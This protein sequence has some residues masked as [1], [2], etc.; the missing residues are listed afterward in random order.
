MSPRREV[1]AK[2]EFYH[3]CS[4]SIAGYVIFNHDLEFSRMLSLIRYYQLGEVKVRFSD[5][6]GDAEESFEEKFQTYSRGKEKRVRM[7]AY[8][9]MP[10]HIH[11]LLQQLE[12]GG[13][14]RY[15][16]NVLNG[17][18]RY[19]NLKHKRR[20]PLWE[21]RFKSILVKIDSQL[22]H[23]T[24]YIHLNPTT[25]HLANSPEEWQYSS[26]RE[27]IAMPMTRKLCD[28]Q[29]LIDLHPEDY[30][31]FVEDRISYQQELAEIKHLILE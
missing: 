3:I 17:Y 16:A 11:L 27:Y 21:A 15:M 9:L 25:A 20:G 6:I 7:I 2:G 28:Y 13:I 31:K 1:L 30:Q 22:L 14:N 12:P 29:N 8:S 26:Y 10:T 4:K 23:L 18:A 19:F 24:R 5:F